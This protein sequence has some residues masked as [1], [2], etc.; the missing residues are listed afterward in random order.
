[1][2]VV[3]TKKRSLVKTISWRV[4]AILNSFLVLTFNVTDNN[5]LNALYMNITG[6]F[7]YYIFDRIWSKINYGRYQ[8]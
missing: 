1:V 8:K 7:I 5:F 6:F 4:V 3:E 2:E